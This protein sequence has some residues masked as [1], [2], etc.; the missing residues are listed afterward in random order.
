MASAVTALPECARVPGSPHA[1]E[2]DRCCGPE[3]AIFVTVI[4][5]PP[6]DDSSAN[7]PSIIYLPNWLTHRSLQSNQKADH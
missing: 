5:R 1:G 7:T 4:L 2:G 6:Y 3:A